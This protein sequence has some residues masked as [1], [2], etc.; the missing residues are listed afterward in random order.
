VTV[1]GR[2]WKDLDR[3]KEAITLKG[4]KGTVAMTAEY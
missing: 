3:N 4:L 1:N 2:K